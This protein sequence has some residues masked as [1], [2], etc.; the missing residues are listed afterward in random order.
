[1]DGRGTRWSADRNAPG[2]D[3]D[4]PH[5]LL[6]DLQAVVEVDRI[7]VDISGPDEW[8][9]TFF[10]S[11]SQD[12]QDWVLL[13]SQERAA[14]V[15]DIRRP[16]LRGFRYLGFSSIWSEDGGQVNVYENEVYGPGS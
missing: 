5:A 14:G 15:F 10:V 6:I 12:L 13:F 7:H 1:M 9:Q 8:K 16:A 2:P 11:A 4:H 3:A